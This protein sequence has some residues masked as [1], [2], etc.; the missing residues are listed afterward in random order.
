MTLVASPK[1]KSTKLEFG[2]GPLTIS[3]R[4]K[5]KTPLTF[6]DRGTPEA[7]IETPVDFP[8]AKHFMPMSILVMGRRGKGKSLTMHWWGGFQ[9]KRYQQFGLAC[10]SSCPPHCTRHYRVAANFWTDYADIINPNLVEDLATFPAWGYK[11]FALIDEIGAQASNRMSMNR[12]NID[13][14]NF[15]TQIR[16]RDCECMFTTQNPQWTEKMVVYQVDL[17]FEADLDRTRDLITVYVWDWWGHWTGRRYRKYWPPEI[18]QSDWELTI[19]NASAH[20]Q[21]YDTKMVVPPRWAK[22]KEQI[23]MQEFGEGWQDQLN[24]GYETVSEAPAAGVRAVPTTLAEIIKYAE[25]Y[26][27]PVD[28]IVR[29]DSLRATAKKMDPEVSTDDRFAAKLKEQGLEPFQGEDGVWRC[30]VQE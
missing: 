26:S 9:K 30:K 18:S 23:I 29:L 11:I 25:Q 16:K 17:F 21:T 8:A 24:V 13:I 4:D 27:M 2:G 28:G 3:P 15:L 14:G 19:L 5:I 6:T 20:F 12:G 22:N 1:K 10:T 7:L